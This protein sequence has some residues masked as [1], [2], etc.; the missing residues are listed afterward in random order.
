MKKKLNFDD[1]DYEHLFINES[2]VDFFY[3]YDN[4]DEQYIQNKE[5]LILK[6][7]DHVIKESE[8]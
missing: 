6:Y 2:F 1:K 4:C 5:N 3:Q 8:N 7:S